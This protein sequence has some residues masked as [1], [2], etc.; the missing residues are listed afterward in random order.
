MGYDRPAEEPMADGLHPHF[1]DRRAVF[2]HAHLADALADAA[3]AGRQVFVQYG[4]KRC[5]G[6]RALVEKTIIKA[7][8]SE[9]L[10]EHFTCLAADAD[11]VEPAVEALVA[12]L[13]RR[14]PTPLCLYLD[15]AGRVLH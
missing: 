3:A 6:S 14:E 10:G 7:E 15:A 11:A 12:A 1:L 9:F 13:P 2:W 4:R 8:V 5:E